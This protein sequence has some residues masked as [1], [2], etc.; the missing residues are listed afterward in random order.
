MMMMMMMVMMMM[1]VHQIIDSAGPSAGMSMTLKLDAISLQNGF[2]YLWFQMQFRLSD[3]IIQNDWSDLLRYHSTSNGRIWDCKNNKRIQTILVWFCFH[4]PS[5]AHRCPIPELVEVA[6]LGRRWVAATVVTLGR[7]GTMSFRSR[8]TVTFLV[9]PWWLYA[10][11]SAFIIIIVM[12][13]IVLSTELSS[14]LEQEGSW[15]HP[16]I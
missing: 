5:H 13:R 2:S 3:L 12:Q 14:W 10:I 11:I 16:E 9:F 8:W 1:I 6:W 15:Q 7:Q 4:L